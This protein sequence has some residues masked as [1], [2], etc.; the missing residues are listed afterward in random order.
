MA[1]EIRGELEIPFGAKTYVV[2]LTF[3]AMARIETAFGLTCFEEVILDDRLGKGDEKRFFPN[4]VNLMKFWRAVMDGN[5][6]A[7]VQI[8]QATVNPWTLA[9]AAFTL[10]SKSRETW[11]AGTAEAAGGEAPLSDAPAGDTGSE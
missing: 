8:E 11:F 5:G 3:D 10:I 2:A 1:N 6:H 9:G 7:D 4:V